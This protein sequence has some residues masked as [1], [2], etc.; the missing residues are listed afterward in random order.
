[1]ITLFLASTTLCI[2][3]IV[4]FVYYKKL[5]PNWLQYFVWYL[6]YTLLF[7]IVA[8]L[9]SHYTKRSNHFLINSN[10]IIEFL[11]Y[12]YIFFKTFQKKILKQLTCIMAVI[13]MLYNLY[14][15]FAGAG[16][17]IYNSSGNS[18]GSVFII[19]CC[20]IYFYSLFQSELNI[21]YFRIPMFWIA[22][23]LLFFLVGN[24]LYLA[25]LNYILDYRLDPHANFYL[26]INITLNLLLYS[27]FTCGFLSNQLWKKET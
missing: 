20:L 15:I 10:I 25:L 6:L 2:S 27:L 18:I 12:F 4:G 26:S 14:Y 16:I 23:G 11:F 19:I 24:A 1:M 5:Q 13:Y 22:T 3:I 9:Y 7:E 8:Y 21:N 17:F